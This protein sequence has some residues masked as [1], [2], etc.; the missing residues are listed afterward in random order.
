MAER[1]TS[2]TEQTEQVKSPKR[3]W[4]RDLWDTYANLYRADPKNCIR[5]FG[6]AAFSAVGM[7]VAVPFVSAVASQNLS[8]AILGGVQTT[9]GQMA[10]AATTSV[11]AYYGLRAMGNVVHTLF[12]GCSVWLQDAIHAHFYDKTYQQIKKNAIQLSR[13][14]NMEQLTSATR[15][16]IRS[17]VQAGQQAILVGQDVMALTLAGAMV[18]A[19]GSIVP[20]LNA[21]TMAR[22]GG[23]PANMWVGA[24]AVA[25]VGANAFVA[26]YTAKKMAPIVDAYKEKVRIVEAVESEM[27][28][29]IREITRLGI[30]RRLYKRLELA[31]KELREAA[32]RQ[33]LHRVGYGVLSLGTG[34]I[35]GAVLGLGSAYAAWSVGNF[36][37]YGALT[38][39]AGMIT[40]AGN[41]V[42]AGYGAMKE[43]WQ[44]YRKIC[45]DLNDLTRGHH[46]T[47]EETRSGSRTIEADKSDVYLQKKIRAL[48]KADLTLTVKTLE[49]PV[50]DQHGQAQKVLKADS[51]TFGTGLHFVVG[52]SGSGKSTLLET[53]S[54]ERYITQGGVYMGAP[55]ISMPRN[56]D[57]SLM[58]VER[59]S[60]WE[61]N[62]QDNDEMCLQVQS[63][64]R[65]RPVFFNMDDMTV[66]D[67]LAL[68]DK[69]AD[70]VKAALKVAGIDAKDL[71]EG[72]LEKKA[73][74]LST[75]EKKRLSI[76][77]SLLMDRK[78]MF[79]D[80]PESGLG[81]AQKEQIF[82]TLRELA[83][84]HVVVVS[85]HYMSAIQSGDSVTCV[86][87]NGKIYQGRAKDLPP[88]SYFKQHW[89]VPATKKA[90][91]GKALEGPLVKKSLDKK[92]MN[93]SSRRFWGKPGNAM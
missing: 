34:I 20:G 86:E 28:R 21:G 6:L 13:S 60:Y 71:K 67:N 63:F 5:V 18:F 1:T 9:A 58:P 65:A 36:G 38:A 54:G 43:A 93:D 57:E 46:H 8:T 85:T 42:A 3:S 88:D 52:A 27:N 50:E 45:Q 55:V 40:S 68:L 25:V 29:K 48:N 19:A 79:F 80:E 16:A 72:F 83:K 39:A 26:H 33:F 77:Q 70:E 37:L 59:T 76:A 91:N 15:Q 90:E 92:A 12:R 41:N 82:A 62:I 74:E 75:G 22:F 23:L 24:A 78:I 17:Q 89:S 69:S 2:H 61:Q 31:R 30:E 81:D 4:F 35:G 87:D 84:D 66:G 51:L 49:V 56:E 73:S 44:S 53:L 64:A 14:L 7:G 47:E 10:V 32:R 11:A